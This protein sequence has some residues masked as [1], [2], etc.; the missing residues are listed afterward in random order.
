MP[1]KIN[2]NDY[3][4]LSARVHA[5]EGRMLTR[6]RIG[7]MLDAPTAEEAAKV[8]T[9]CGYEEMSNLTP[10]AIDAVL[11]RTREAIFAD[12]RKAMP[13]PRL[14]DV[15]GIKY[16]YHNIKALIKAEAMGQSA[17]HLLLSG[18]RYGAAALKADYE[19]DDLR[20]VS[21]T[22]RA[23][24]A[25]AKELLATAGDPQRADLVLDRAYFA[26]LLEAAD[27]TGSAFLR[28]YA[29]LLIDSANLRAA[30]RAA[31]M[32]R[33]LHFLRAA[34]LPGG[35]VDPALIA[36]AAL[37]GGDLAG[38]F[39]STLLREAADLGATLLGGGSLTEFERLCDN[40]VTAYLAA[41]RRVSFGEQPV[42]GYLYA[43]EAELT[44]IR[45]ILAGKLAGLSA[46][47]L[48]ERLRDTYV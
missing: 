43:R 48:R 15:F 19:K 25:E 29:V 41:G 4:H 32:G 45:V 9:E 36:E 22:F 46:E 24:V 26:E 5:L 7:R 30:V 3:L 12:L 27:A 21:D 16:D 39:S 14:A 6:E 37:G 17:D 11:S 2:E 23:A 40:A 34:L 44:A 8:I 18:G 13:D 33:D 28:G 1:S 38:R 42:V 10:A 47:I 20:H 35:S 31:R